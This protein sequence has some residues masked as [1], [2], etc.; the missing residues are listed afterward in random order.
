MTAIGEIRKGREIGK[1][2]SS[3]NYIWQP[4][5][6]CGKPRWVHIIKEQPQSQICFRCSRKN[7]TGS[8]WKWNREQIEK[9]TGKNNIR[10][11]GGRHITSD[12]YV[13]IWL[14]PDDFFYLMTSKLRYVLEHR[15]VMARK[16]GRCLQSWEVVHHKNGIRNDNRLENLE[17]TTIGSHII[18]HSNGYRD[19]FNK[20][21]NDGKDKRVKELLAKNKE[22]EA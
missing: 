13:A 19:G 12:G 8:H 4:C 3:Q 17:L 16:L 10:W 18:E 21:Y 9:V 1:A 6:I 20:G 15:L 7:F 22:L 14:S 2:Q 11:K 5:G